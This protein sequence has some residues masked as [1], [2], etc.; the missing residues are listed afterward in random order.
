M[1]MLEDVFDMLAKCRYVIPS[2]LGAVISASISPLQ[3]ADNPGINRWAALLIGGSSGYY[4]GQAAV[5]Y[6]HIKGEYLPLSMCLAIAIFS[7]VVLREA[8]RVLPGLLQIVTSRFKE[9]IGGG[10]G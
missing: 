10:N 5:E 9:K 4:F 6:W 3:T 7:V 8:M 2:V 1:A